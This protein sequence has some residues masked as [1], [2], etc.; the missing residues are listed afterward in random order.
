MSKKKYEW[1]NSYV[2]FSK[3]LKKEVT[4]TTQL[5]PQIQS[6]YIIQDNNPAMQGGITIK[7][8]AKLHKG[9]LKEEEK[10][11]ITNLVKGRLVQVEIENGVLTEIK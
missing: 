2:F 1:C 8:M 3:E 6:V 10:E 9:L 4:L 11:E 5:Y 7:D